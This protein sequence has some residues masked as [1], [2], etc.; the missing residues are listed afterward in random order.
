MGKPFTGKAGIITGASSGLGR[1]IAKGLGAAG[2]ELWLVGRSAE[3]LGHTANAITELGGPKAH[4][5]SLDLT[6]PGA[7]ADLVDNVSARHP[8]LFALINNAGVMYPE[9]IVDADPT[10]WHDMFAVNLLTPMEG[11]RAAVKAMRAHGQ[12][13]HLI[14]IS[15]LASRDDVYG[16]YGVTKIA[17]NHVGRTLRK[18]LEDDDIRVTTIVPGGFATNLIRGFDEQS[19]QRLQDKMAQSGLDPSGPDSK[20]IMADPQHVANVIEYILSQPIELNIEEITIRPAKD[21]TL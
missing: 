18:E 11:C 10:R 20:K 13:A 14:N 7:L 15:S 5:A 2:M 12:P 6:Q 17:L 1:A 19:L 3:E 21:L 8:Y 9:P 16:A 4:C